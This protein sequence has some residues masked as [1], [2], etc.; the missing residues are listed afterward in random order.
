[1]RLAGFL[2]TRRRARA[3]DGFDDELRSHLE[4]H[5]DDCVR[6]GMTPDEARRA[7]V[8]K[9][10]GIESA[11]QRYRERASIP[12]LEQLAQDLRFGA[13]QLRGAPGFTATAVMTLSLGI[14]A[15]LSIFAFV[16][17]ALVQPLPYARPSRLVIATGRTPDIPHASLSHPDFLDWKRMNTVFTALEAHKGGGVSLDTRD[18]VQ[19]VSVARVTAGFFR[20]LGVQPVFGRDFLDGEDAAG[21]PRVVILSHASWQARYGGSPKII[22]RSLTLSGE[23]A[24]IVGVLPPS[25]HFAP[26]GRAE[27]WMPF[28]ATS[29]CDLRRS[30]HSMSGVGRLKEAVTVEEA[31][32][33]LSRIAA[34]L[35]RE[36]PDSNRGQGASVRPLG[37]AITGELRPT[38]LTLLGG[39]VLLLVIA[40]VNV[41]SLLLVRSEGRKRELAVRRTLGASGGRLVRQFVTEA[42]VLVGAATA[43]GVLL[44]SGAVRLLFGLLSEDMLQELPFLG[45]AAIDTR[46]LA[47][48][49]AI[50]IVSTLL[51]TLAPA[52]RVRAGE[53]REGLAEGARGSS[54]TAWRRL[55]FRLVVLEIAIAM[56][57]LVGAGLLGQSLHRLLSVELGFTP[58]RLATLQVAAV[59]SRFDDDDAAIRVARQVEARA[60]ALPGVQA[61]GLASVLPVSFNGNTDWIRIVGRPWNGRHI[62]VNMRE[63]SAGYFTALG[64]HVVSGR[65]FGADDTAQ[66]PKVA[67]INRTLA[68]THFPNQNPIG[69]RFGDRVLTPDS[70]KEIIGVVDDIREGPLDA[71]VWPAVYYPLEQSPSRSFAILART[72]QDAG[73]VLPSLDAAIRG[74]DP[75]LGTRDG[76]VMRQRITNS[77]VAYLRRSS[78]WLVGGFAALALLLSVIGLYGV[79]AYS[80]GQ[81]TREIGLRV[82]MGAERGAVYRLIMG[83]AAR[84][85]AVGLALGAG[86]AVGSARLIQS[87]LFG[88][89]PWDVPTLAGV[90]IVLAAAS[91]MA[92][93]IP[94]RRAA[95]V[96]PVDALRME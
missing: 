3:E 96:N 43:L 36:Y 85:V 16:D 42:V 64:S 74:I 88:T 40:W 35:E 51:S 87:L 33:E 54:G 21:A 56:V 30:C 13:R 48:A 67:I 28:Q 94:A 11:R 69:Q 55:G 95:E 57:L 58:D 63:V 7:A 44:A 65:P 62:E 68:A 86:A 90:A 18:G 31:Q 73:T 5:I 32:A 9:L 29:G 53:L 61:V 77:P 24:T 66:R 6:A 72:S 47:A 34:A 79:V 37:E 45:E 46:V 89:S 15:A 93:Y 60:S 20:V 71:D 17:A 4:L 10:G 82:A 50:G 12:W 25:F 14:A 80:V 91:L 59:G 81:R 39:A 27:L 38:L 76:I 23:P 22:G 1:M 83:E 75:D 19:L 70:I 26:R 2:S 52:V 84:V 78:A 92:S 41:V 8:L 49:A